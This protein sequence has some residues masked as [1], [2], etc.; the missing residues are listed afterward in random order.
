MEGD[1]HRF[2]VHLYISQALMPRG[3][4]AYSGFVDLAFEHQSAIKKMLQPS[5]VQAIIMERVLKLR[6]SFSRCTKV[7]PKTNYDSAQH[8][9]LGTV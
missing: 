9:S 7:M 6:F 5:H 3:G 1:A 2:Q 4:T 8:L